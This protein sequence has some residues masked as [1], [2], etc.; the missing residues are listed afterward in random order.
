MRHDWIFDVLKDLRVFAQKNGLPALA[1]QVETAMRVARA[2][3]G[4]G[5]T[6]KIGG[7]IEAP[8][9]GPGAGQTH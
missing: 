7:E 1:A 5:E 9:N 2:E 4:D 3:I 6:A 8:G